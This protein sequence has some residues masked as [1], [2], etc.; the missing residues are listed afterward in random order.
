MKGTKEGNARDKEEWVVERDRRERERKQKKASRVQ[1]NPLVLTHTSANRTCKKILVQVPLQSNA[2]GWWP[3][4]KKGMKSKKMGGWRR[5]GRVSSPA[6][7]LARYTYTFSRH[8]HADLRAS[9]YFN[10]VVGGWSRRRFFP[11]SLLLSL[12]FSLISSESQTPW[13]HSWRAN[14]VEKIKAVAG[15]H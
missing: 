2:G 4:G 1:R 13:S 8:S 5:R 11:L 14:E 10:G 3:G 6:E 7:L 9:K 15:D 12:S